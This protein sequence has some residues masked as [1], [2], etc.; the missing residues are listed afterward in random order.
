MA[1][2][3][4]L[5][6][7][8]VVAKVPL[9]TD[10]DY[11]EVALNYADGKLYFKNSSNVIQSF[12][13]D[14]SS[15][16][17]LTGTQTLTNKTLSSSILTG[18]LT[19]GGGVGS[20]GQV[21]SSTGT[22]VQ[23][24]NAGSGSGS[25]GGSNTQL[26]Y[27][28]AG[29]FGGISTLTYNGTTVSSSADM[30][31]NGVVLGR[32]NGNVTS[33]LILGSNVFL[34]NTIA[35][36]NVLNTAIGN[37][38]L[39]YLS[40]GAMGL[41]IVDQGF[42]FIDGTY[43]LQLEY[44]SGA[45]AESYPTARL[46]FFGGYLDTVDMLTTGYNFTGDTTIL[47]ST[48]FGTIGFPNSDL[49]IGLTG[50]QYATRNLA[51]GNSAGNTT[52][53]GS[54]NIYIGGATTS[55]RY[56]SYNEIIIGYAATGNG[57]NSITLGNSSILY[58][59]LKGAVFVPELSVTGG[60][61]ANGQLNL[62]GSA[63]SPQQI[64][65]NQTSGT[66][67]IGGISSSIN[68][69]T[70]TL[71]RATGTSTVNIGNGIPATSRTKTINIGTSAT[72]P[73]G[74][75]NI[76]IGANALTT[77]TIRGP[78]VTLAALG[79][80]T[81]NGFSFNSP[82]LWLQVSKY[83]N[84]VAYN[85][86]G[87]RMQAQYNS[88]NNTETLLFDTPELSLDKTTVIRYEFKNTQ[89]QVLNTNDAMGFEFM[90]T[91]GTAYL[92]II[93]T[94]GATGVFPANGY[95]NLFAMQRSDAAVGACT[96]NAGGVPAFTNKLDDGSGNLIV[97]GDASTI[98]SSRYLAVKHTTA[99]TS[100]TTGAL[101]VAGGAGIAG[102]LN[103]G[104]GVVIT[105]NLTVNGTTTTINSTT[106]SVDDK[107]IELGSITTPTNTTADGGGITLKG[108]TDKTFNWINSTLSWTSSEHLDLA[109][110]KAYYIASTAVLSSTA[111][112]TGVVTSSLTSVGTITS[113]TWSGGFGAVSGANLTN[114]T[115]SN[116][117][118]TIP[119]AVLGNSTVYIGS[120]AV[121]LNRATGSLDLTGI[122]SIDGSAATLTTA[123]TINGVSF[124][125]SA[126]ITVTANTT[127]A[128]T[129]GTGLSG[130]SFNG[131]GAVTIAIDSTVATL[132]GS[133]T[134]TNKTIN[135]TSNTLVATSAQ[136]LAAMTDETGTGSL[137]FATS[138]T[139]VTPNIGDA[140]ATKV[141]L[142]NGTSNLATMDVVQA[143]VATVTPTAIDTWALA[144]FRSA[145]YTVQITQGTNY[146]VTEI[147]VLHNGTTT[148]NTQYAQVETNGQLATFTTDVASTNAR[149]LVT[150]G[151]AT[152]ATI[153]IQAT[154]MAV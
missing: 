116:L 144:S 72:T 15:Y 139:L 24:V 47:T 3:V 83:I 68:A 22:G 23:W 89:M 73:A 148:F 108:T 103:V 129:I 102:D 134:L 109:T 146:Q 97:G 53:S 45:T 62:Y 95:R 13:S 75:T 44:S 151:S 113:G 74:T 64:A 2:K 99:S 141:T 88:S 112:G 119:S 125:G 52:R 137:V 48:Q 59:Y 17:T 57:N 76:N 126:N 107:N 110:G 85:N 154:M 55:S 122:T 127:N 49:Y 36:G 39:Q 29:A 153:N 56:D 4:L 121:A 147:L 90:A 40:N 92:G 98:N 35:S 27:N 124:N 145:K 70:I 21:L 115:A 131:S 25:P 43:D 150:M 120:T 31:I 28:N 101:Q 19:A 118:G 60:L 117:T 143:T 105:G 71:G 63:T 86:A 96:P 10:L 32:G 16:A 114:L 14:V 123:R 152:S 26:Q 84:N 37:N 80:P 7:S 34:A 51:I 5:K 135:L 140:T 54:N 20:A 130:T 58:T 42:G 100:S 111:L 81:N 87:F 11:G 93:N 18:T 50:L 61:T 8:S 128:L 38:T 142:N 82:A 133:Q 65:T 67:T 78:A 12:N 91:Y 9:T 149:L 41:Y 132:T 46:T 138:P 94:G 104:G 69:G 6:K 136:L 33:N 1:N 79:T 30:S 66:L 77:T 106:I